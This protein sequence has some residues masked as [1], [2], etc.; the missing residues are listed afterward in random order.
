M[1][2]EKP[3]SASTPIR[4]ARPPNKPIRV[5]LGFAYFN[6]MA[7]IVKVDKRLIQSM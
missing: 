6:G 1:Q 2:K 5:Q 4:G 3:V 7:L